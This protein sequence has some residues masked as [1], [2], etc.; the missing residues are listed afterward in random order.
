MNSPLPGEL[1]DNPQQRVPVWVRA[2]D[3]ALR[4]LRLPYR[5]AHRHDPLREMTTLEQRVNLFHLLDQ[6]L[7]GDIPGDIIEIG[8][9]TGD[10]AVLLQR[11]NER[12]PPPREFHVYDSFAWSPTGGDIRAVFETAFRTANLPLPQIHAGLFEETLP[13]QL[14]DTIAFAHFDCGVGDNRAA[15]ARSLG[16]A[17]SAVVP[18]MPRGAIGVLMDYFDP[19]AARTNH[20]PGARDAADAYF[21]PRG[22]VIIPLHGGEYCHAFFRKA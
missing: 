18:R 11:I 9:Y 21:A 8:C 6:V 19:A 12:H 17:L 2:A 14:P 1:Y 22:E 10:T 7:A 16:Y 20:N 5:L 15:H 3:L 13:A 4:A